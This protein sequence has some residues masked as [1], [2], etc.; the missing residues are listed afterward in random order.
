MNVDY[1]RV[2]HRYIRNTPSD[3]KVHTEHQLRVDRRTLPVEKK[4]I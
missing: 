2:L 3:T 4:Y 1:I